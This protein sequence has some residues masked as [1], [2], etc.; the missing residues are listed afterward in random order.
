MS[1]AFQKSAFQNSAYQVDPSVL[2]G[3][4]GY[5]PSQGRSPEEIWAEVKARGTSEQRQI[6]ESKTPDQIRRE[7][8]EYGILPKVQVVIDEVAQRQVERLETDSQ[9][10][11]DELYGEL[12][13]NSIEWDT[14][15]LQSLSVQR[16]TLINEE[17]RKRLRNIQDEKDIV[18][19][20]QLMG[21]VV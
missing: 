4:G 1:G 5:H 7:R 16:E 9:K 11:F 2:A 20:L 12:K 18:S 8:E 19:I 14:R 17:I 10:Q 13:F 15:Y 21:G 6:Q 3:G